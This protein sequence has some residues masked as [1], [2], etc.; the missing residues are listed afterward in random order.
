MP[1]RRWISYAAT[2][3]NRLE[4][5]VARLIDVSP[6][7]RATC[8]SARGSSSGP[9]SRELLRWAEPD[10]AATPRFTAVAI[11]LL[12]ERPHRGRDRKAE[13]RLRRGTSHHRTY[14]V[15]Q[16]TGGVRLRPRL[17]YRVKARGAARTPCAQHEARDVVAPRD[18]IR[19]SAGARA[20]SAMATHEWSAGAGVARLLGH[21][22]DRPQART[23]SDLPTSTAARRATV[24]FSRADGRVRRRS[25]AH[26]DEPATIE[27][28]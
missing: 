18:R 20:A 21:D 4:P 23:S 15:A 5:Y 19:R 28:G 13:V 3:D 12:A 25:N 16:R 24:P 14:E 6:T 11:L 1:V 10:N 26:C 27:A 9:A 2:R 7:R 17:L 8:E 22:P